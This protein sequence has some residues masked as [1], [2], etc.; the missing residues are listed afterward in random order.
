MKTEKLI[1]LIKGTVSKNTVLP[2]L[3]SVKIENNILTAT[4]LDIVL[5]VPDID[6]KG[7]G[8]IYYK[9]FINTIK[10]IEDCTIKIKTKKKVRIFN[11]TESIEIA[12]SD[13]EYFPKQPD[14]SNSKRI[15]II[16]PKDFE[17]I[18]T[19]Q[20]F[21]SNDELRPG[22]L[23][24][25]VDKDIVATNG[26]YMFFEKVSEPVKQFY[27]LPPKVINLIKIMYKGAIQPIDV[28]ANE[29]YIILKFDSATIILRKFDA[30]YPDY[31]SVI[32][33][34][35]STT[36]EVD[37]KQFAHIVTNAIKFANETTYQIIVTINKNLSISSSNLDWDKSYNSTIPINKTGTNITTAFNGKMMLVIL[38]NIKAEK[39]TL[40]FTSPKEAIIIQDKFLLMPI[41][42]NVD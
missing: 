22:M 30:K 20:N 8:L 25:Y 12:M 41:M 42:L 35:H 9:D 11:K 34:K 5:E 33:T 40:K 4:D 39:V 7:K 32:P 15:H 31:Q 38:N 2:V 3:E 26:S 24:V 17:K 27:L 28:R 36:I 14:I 23:H 19:A 16:D 13:I 21:I 18:L 37:K 1:K 29:N 6:I 10:S